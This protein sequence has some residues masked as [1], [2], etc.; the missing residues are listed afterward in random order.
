[1]RIARNEE[2]FVRSET[3][4]VMITAIQNCI[5]QIRRKEGENEKKLFCTK[6]EKKK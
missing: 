3:K 4:W 5:Q 1:M 2:E 6:K